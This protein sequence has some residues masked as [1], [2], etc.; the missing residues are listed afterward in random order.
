MGLIIDLLKLT[1]VFGSA[2]DKSQNTTKTN[3]KLG[4]L[5]T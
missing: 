4:G 1:L 5:D 3:E 2:E